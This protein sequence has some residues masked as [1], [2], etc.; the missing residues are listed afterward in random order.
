MESQYVRSLA[1]PH[2]L[3]GAVMKE[4]KE[5]SKRAVLVQLSIS[6][7]TAQK[8][9]KRVTK[10]V[11]AD[12]AAAADA[13]RWNK[14]LLA[15]ADLHR[16]VVN[17]AANARN[18]FYKHTLPW[19][20]EGRRLLPTSNFFN[21]TEKMRIERGKFDEALQLFIPAYPQ[22]KLEA[23]LRQGT[24]HDPEDFPSDR[25]VEKKFSWDIGFEPLPMNGD[26]RV[27]LPPE[28]LEGIEAASAKRVEVAVKGAMQDVWHRL[29]QTVVKVKN[30]AAIDGL[31]RDDLS[32]RVLD[33]LSLLADL[34]ATNDSELDEMILKVGNELTPNPDDLRNNEAVR[35]AVE[36]KADAILDVMRSFCA[37]D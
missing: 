19:T 23:R 22:L 29:H 10:K 12:H 5:V 16:A 3:I 7:W 2:I 14:H 21:F 35:S 20:D 15:G 8:F 26:F 28:E 25:E 31:V 4:V 30:A 13:G 17:A 9:D 11:N 36:K 33:Q 24:M 6:C 18:V 37:K 27:N 32:T 34:N 1:S